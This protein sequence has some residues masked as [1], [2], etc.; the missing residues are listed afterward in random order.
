MLLAILMKVG[1]ERG[2]TDELLPTVRKKGSL[3]EEHQKEFNAIEREL[4]G[5]KEDEAGA[6]V[7]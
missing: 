2:E 5:I 1:R 7:L 4:K 3:I 6:P